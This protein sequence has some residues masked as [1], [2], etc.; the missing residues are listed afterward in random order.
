VR[1]FF[2]GGRRAHT[3]P[4]RVGIAG[5]RLPCALTVCSRKGVEVM[6]EVGMGM[7][8]ACPRRFHPLPEWSMDRTLFLPVLP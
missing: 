7:G 1:F 5:S 8:I 4:W 3:T 6:V 2:A